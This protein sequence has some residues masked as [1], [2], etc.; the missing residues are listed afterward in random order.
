VQSVQPIVLEFFKKI[1][2][3]PLV[4]SLHAKEI[5]IPPSVQVKFSHYRFHE[6]NKLEVRGILSGLAETESS[7]KQG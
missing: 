6:K 3:S 1:E 2:S 5:D 4:V 7:S